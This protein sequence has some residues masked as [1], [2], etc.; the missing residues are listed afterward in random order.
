MASRALTKTQVNRARVRAKR[1]VPIAELARQHSVSRQTMRKAVYGITYK[2]CATR[3]VKNPKS[4]YIHPNR[5]LTV[6]QV[7]EMRLLRSIDGWSLRQLSVMLRFR[8][9]TVDQNSRA[10]TCWDSFSLAKCGASG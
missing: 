3:A 4:G 9:T 10:G 8:S 6:K 2:D 7:R 1:G 5:K